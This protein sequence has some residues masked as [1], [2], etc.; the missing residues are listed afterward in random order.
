MNQIVPPSLLFDVQLSIPRCPK[1][2]SRKTGR[3][4][5]LPP[6]SRLLIPS[7]LNSAASPAELRAAWNDDG[8]AL[9]VSVVDKQAPVTGSSKDADGS[10]CVL[11][12]VDTRPS[13]N[14]HRATEYCHHFAC[15][16]VDGHTDG[17]PSVVVR[18]IA[19]QR[20]QR[21]ESNPAKM[22]C[23]THLTKHGYELELWIPGS[24]LYGYREIAEIGR[25]G[26]YCVV[27]DTELG[28][29]HLSVDDSFP[30]AWDPSLWIQL[31]LMS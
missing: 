30:F 13:G 2:S 23:R 15:I 6:E 19:Q 7:I 1:P 8:F 22:I 11:I 12:W 28:D 14:V 24:Q 5:K 26:F 4:L 3:L 29:R 17:S 9:Q 16:P 31:E 10:D 27:Q 25:I 20:S 18:P 21:I